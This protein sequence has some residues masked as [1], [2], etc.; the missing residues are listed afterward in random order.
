MALVRWLVGAFL[1]WDLRRTFR[2]VCWVGSQLP[3]LPDSPVIA[4]SNHHNFYDGHLAWLLFR[5]RLRRRPTIWME[6]WD[7]YPFFAA[8]GAQPFPP[9]T[10]TRRAATIRRTSRQFQTHP[11]TVLVYFP[12]GT[13]HA[14][15]EGIR[16]FSPDAT[17]RLAQLYPT[18]TWWPYAVH[19]TW[20]NEA[21]PTALLT[22][23]SP[24]EAD[25]K[26]RDRLQRLWQRLRS[27]QDH[28]TV[29]LLCGRGSP[30]ERWDFSFVSSFF[31]RYL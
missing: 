28:P 26:E 11:N 17:A 7:R 15:E 2:R 20:R 30:E 8:L 23:G 29:P 12:E 5:T 19:V 3:E 27:G 14:P 9:D 25:G 6:E 4:Y 13:L 21:T 31:E 18:A 1:R 24:H 16:T 10:P 22:G